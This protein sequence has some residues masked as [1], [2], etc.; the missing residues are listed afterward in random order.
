MAFWLLALNFALMTYDAR[1]SATKQRKIR[2]IAQTL[3]VSRSKRTLPQARRIWVGG[4]FGRYL[5][6]R[7]ASTENEQLRAAS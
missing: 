2:S 5:E 7:R 3:H 4:L 1:D 6:L